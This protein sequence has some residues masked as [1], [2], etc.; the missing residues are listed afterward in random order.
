MDCLKKQ[1]K[2]RA[3][4]ASRPAGRRVHRPTGA[5]NGGPRQERRDGARLLPL[6][7]KTGIASPASEPDS[8]PNVIGSP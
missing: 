1:S 4:Q 8:M 2:H 6:L 5:G 7:T 3:N